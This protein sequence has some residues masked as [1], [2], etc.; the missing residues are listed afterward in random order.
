MD[1]GPEMGGLYQMF[2]RKG[3]TVGGIFNKP[4]AMPGPPIW[5]YYVHV[6]DAAATASAIQAAGGRLISGPMEVPGGDMVA[7][8]MDPQGAAFCVHAAVTK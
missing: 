6:E 3:R 8:F 1:M 7:H 2:T 5:L 4:A